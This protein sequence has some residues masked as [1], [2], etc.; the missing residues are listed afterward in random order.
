VVSWERGVALDEKYLPEFHSLLK[1]SEAI[2][3]VVA[4]NWPM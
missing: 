2:I 1:F 3:L 4:L